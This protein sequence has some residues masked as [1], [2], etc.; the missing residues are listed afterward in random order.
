MSWG[1]LITALGIGTGIWY[2]YVL[3]RYYRGE[4]KNSLRTKQP[5][6]WV[7]EERAAADHRGTPSANKDQHAQV[8]E[9]MQELKLV[10][11]AVIRDHLEQEQVLQAV[12]QRL[13][14]Y[15]GLPSDIKQSIAHHLIHEFSLQ[16]KMTI[17]EH[18]INVLW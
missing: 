3:V 4:L 6:K 9:L 10:F 7:R 8:H 17:T 2:G 5:V 15:K 1:E 14:A 16:L 13:M 11:V 18:Q 12:G